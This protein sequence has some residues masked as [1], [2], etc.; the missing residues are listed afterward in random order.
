[1]RDAITFVEEKLIRQ[2]EKEEWSRAR[3]P[4]SHVRDRFDFY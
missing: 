4:S 3:S 1:M 2:M